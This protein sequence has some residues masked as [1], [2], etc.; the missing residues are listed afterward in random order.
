MT[1]ELWDE[2][3]RFGVTKLSVE[4]GISRQAIH[5]WK[6]RSRIPPEHFMSLDRTLTIPTHEIALAIWPDA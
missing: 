6:I 4:L 3:Q 1:N 2:I 5:Q